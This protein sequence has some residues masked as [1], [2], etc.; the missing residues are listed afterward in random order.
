M[1]LGSKDKVRRDTKREE[2]TES[3]VQLEKTPPGVAKFLK[4][5]H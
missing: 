2:V 5:I 4:V 1:A 3:L